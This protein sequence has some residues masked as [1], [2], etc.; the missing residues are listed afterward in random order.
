MLS[1][2]KYFLSYQ[3]RWILDNSPLKIIQKSRQVGI[4]YAEAYRCVR[5]VSHAGARFDIFIT[6]RDRFQA[7]LSIEDCKNWADILH[8][9]VQDLGE[10]VFDE[11]SN[12]SAYVLQ[13]A[14]GRRIYSLSSNPNAL[15]GKRGD[16][17]I[18]EFA[19]HLDQ[20]LLYRIA[21]PITTW[22]GT[23]SIISTHRGAGTVFNQLIRDITQ[24]GNPMGFSLHTVSIHD[25]IDQGLVERINAKT[26]RHESRAAFLER[27]HAEC[28]DEEQWNQEYCCLPADEN[29]AFISYASLDAAEDPTIR[30]MSLPE[31]IAFATHPLPSDGRGIKGEGSPISSLLSPIFYVGVD[32]AR[33]KH[34]CV[35][36]LGQKIG[37][38]MWDRLRIELLDK[39]FS[40]IR[41]NLY[42][43]LELPQV[44][45]C[46]IDKTGIG[47]Q[48]SEE[49]HIR[50]G[51]KAEPVFITNQCKQR[52]AFALRTQFEDH[53]VR[54]PFD[55]KLRADLRGIK[56][57]VT[58]SGNITFT[59]DTDDSHCDRF[60]A[61]ALRQEAARQRDEPWALVG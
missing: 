34:L 29:T 13:F 28:I 60:W 59:G 8:L 52:L 35:I 23:L 46:C 6:S 15:A 39:P 5:R 42:A 47:H 61:K 40:E 49:A 48:L 41:R 7:K 45:R 2:S 10:I 18:D 33:T 51:Y 27:L 58:P 12:V 20:R 30:L 31:F 53:N 9:L 22:G 37:D 44:Q 26:G 11:T 57:D 36:D 56:K 16:V 24:N 21:K 14:N 19:L 17:V 4:S 38:V 25:A 1:D 50:F 55:P 3:Y 43:L 32:V 54:I